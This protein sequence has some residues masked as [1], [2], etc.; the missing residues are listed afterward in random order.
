MTN[1]LLIAVGGA[2]GSLARFGM[3][4]L[5]LRLTERSGFPWGTLAVN[6]IGCLLIGALAALLDGRII[7]EEYRYLL[8]VGLLGGFTTFS[9]FGLE[10]AQML[11][12]GEWFRLGAYLLLSNVVGIA[13]VLATYTAIRHNR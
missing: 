4:L 13:L 3:H 11:R 10:S 6:L 12:H 8:V 1:L 9:A 2:T 7:R 5:F